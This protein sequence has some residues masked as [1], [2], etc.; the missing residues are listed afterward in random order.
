MCPDGQLLAAALSKIL[1][2]ALEATV[3]DE[4][5]SVH[6]TSSSSHKGA[7]KEVALPLIVSY[8]TLL[9]M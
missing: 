3:P 8:A 9:R 5:Q 1:T 6:L 4:I 7:L 2:T